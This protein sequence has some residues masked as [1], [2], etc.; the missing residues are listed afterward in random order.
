MAGIILGNNGKL[1]LSAYN[2][3]S[4]ETDSKQMEKNLSIKGG[5]KVDKDTLNLISMLGNLLKIL[6]W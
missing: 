5:E 1:W 4:K 3:N 6:S 2:R